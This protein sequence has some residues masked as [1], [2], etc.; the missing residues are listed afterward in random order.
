MR[1]DLVERAVVCLRIDAPEASAADVGDSRAELDAE[2]PEYPEDEIG[3][4]TGIGHNFREVGVGFLAQHNAKELQAVAQ[5]TRHND[6]VEPH[7]R[8]MGSNGT[9]TEQ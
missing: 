1:G 2:Q 3:I 8:G 5:R 6:T 7:I 9:V 4:S